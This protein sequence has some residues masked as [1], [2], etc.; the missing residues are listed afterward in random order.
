M[1]ILAYDFQIFFP[2]RTFS[3]NEIKIPTYSFIILLHKR[4]EIFPPYSIIWHL[5]V[6]K[7]PNKRV[8]L[9]KRVGETIFFLLLENECWLDFK[10]KK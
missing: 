3:C 7:C 2:S 1:S 4:V 8:I 10:K 6:L 5:R 9:N